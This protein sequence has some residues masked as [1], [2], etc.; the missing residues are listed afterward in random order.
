MNKCIHPITKYSKNDD[1]QLFYNILYNCWKSSNGR[2]YED[3]E[4]RNIL[5]NLLLQTSGKYT[6]YPNGIYINLLVTTIFMDL[7]DIRLNNLELRDFLIRFFMYLEEQRITGIIPIKN[8]T[9]K[10][11][12][13]YY[14][15]R[16]NVLDENTISNTHIVMILT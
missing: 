12:L 14:K 13:K 3:P 9:I 5:E 11:R 8:Q 10:D 16:I 15:Q 1:I 2:L 6:Y 7:N 4:I